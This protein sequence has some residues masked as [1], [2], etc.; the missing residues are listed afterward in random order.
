MRIEE[1]PDLLE[2]KPVPAPGTTAFGSGWHLSSDLYLSRDA[3]LA[4]LYLAAS[5]WLWCVACPRIPGIIVYDLGACI[6]G[7]RAEAA[8]PLQLFFPMGTL[9]GGPSP[10]LSG[11]ETTAA[12][13][14]WVAQTDKLLG[15]LTNFANYCAISGEFIPRR[16]FE[17]VM[18][19]E[20]LGRRI[21]G[22]LAHER[23]VAT[24]KAL[25]FDAFDT[26]R[27]LGDI[28]LFEGAKLSRA[29]TVLAALEND[30]PSAAADLLLRPA[31]RAVDALRHVQSGFFLPSR[32][33]G[34]TVRLPDRSGGERNWSIDE[35]V[36]LYLQLL[37][38]ANHG[39]TP[40]ADTNERRDQILLMAHDGD[41]P[42]DVALLPY[43]YWLDTVA[44]PDRFGRRLRP[45]NRKR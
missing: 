23:D 27:G 4:P 45:R 7:R 9:S 17:A 39:F 5:P 13:T 40:E 34:S 20:H 24:R 18:S 43:L 44:H 29:E 10:S 26:M 1:E 6:V 38:N 21:Q 36:A 14:W 41:V 32:T 19:V 11:A 8:E 12:L 31:R 28:D 15:E 2:N 16:L 3:Y 42:G 30:L 35:A 33:S 22:T 25:A 37:R